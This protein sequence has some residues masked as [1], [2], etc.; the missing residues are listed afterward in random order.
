MIDPTT[1]FKMRL[2]ITQTNMFDKESTASTT[3]MSISYI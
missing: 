1:I 3:T 2:F